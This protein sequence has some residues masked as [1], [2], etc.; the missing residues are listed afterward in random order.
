[1][2]KI[3]LLIGV[4]DYES[5]LS[6]LPAAIRDVEAL[7]RVLQDPELGGFDKVNPLINPEPQTMQY[8]IETLFTGCTRDDLVMLYFSGH[9]IKDGSNNL[10]FATRITRKNAK[11]DLIRSSAVSA[12]FVHD[13]LQNSCVRRQAIILDCCFS[14]AFDQQSRLKDDGSV[15]VQRQLGAEGRV[16]LTSSSS[17]QYSLEQSGSALSLY[18]RYLVEGIETGAGDLNEDGHISIQELHHYASD[19]VQA[20]APSMTP[21]LISLKDLGFEIILSKAKVTDPRLRYRRTVAIYATG[22]TISPVIRELLDTI[23]QQLGLTEIE[24]DAIEAEVLRPYQ[25]YFANLQKYQKILL[26]GVE[27]EYPLGN[28]TRD[29]LR[30]LQQLLG[31]RDEDIA[32]IEAPILTQRQ[33]LYDRQQSERLRKEAKLQRQ[34]AKA[35]YKNNLPTALPRLED[36]EPRLPLTRQQFL[37]WTVLGSSGLVVG[38]IG[39]QLMQGQNILEMFKILEITPNQLTPELP[40]LTQRSL[41]DFETVTIDDRGKIIK[42]VL[43]K[44]KFVSEDLG[45]GVMLEMVLIPGGE[46][47]MGTAVNELPRN[48]A[49]TPQHRVKVP[50]FWMDRFAVTQEQWS[51]IAGLPKVNLDLGSDPSNFEGVKRPVEQISWE[52]AVEFCDR[53]SLQTGRSYR[54]PSEAEWEYACRAGTTTPFYVGETITSDLANYDGSIYKNEAQGLYRKQTTD[55]GSFP[56]NAFGLYDMHGNVWEWCQDLWHTDYEGAPSDGTAWLDENENTNRVVRGG[57]WINPPTNCRSAD[58]T[59]VRHN[60]R[61]NIIGFR[62]VYSI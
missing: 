1:M 7:R 5:G 40:E 19:R 56:A 12:Q 18:T 17:T 45:N 44:A 38:L 28:N 43:G 46:F 34:Q 3:A 27:H 58:R 59:E 9:G 15:D 33:I 31:L 2:A 20:T 11:G 4:S 35:K 57:S 60:Y 54:L 41:G 50:E 55:V 26:A 61:H 39:N 29:A 25:E 14:G 16:V 36:S 51:H 37:K 62:V 22:G 42:R 47:L 48:I 23:R 13:I 6:P 49:A 52:E 53:L 30:M 32:T 21:K 10:Y 8:E 24:T